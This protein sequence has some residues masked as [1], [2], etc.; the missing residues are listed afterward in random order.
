MYANCMEIIIQDCPGF[1]IRRIISEK[2][3]VT[4]RAVETTGRSVVAQSLLLFRS[5]TSV[6]FSAERGLEV[7]VFIVCVFTSFLPS[8]HQ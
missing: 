6:S 8:V 3:A 4:S 7:I 2:A 1:G 5:G